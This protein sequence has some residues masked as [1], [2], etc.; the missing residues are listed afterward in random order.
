MTKQ[1]QI[2]LHHMDCMEF[3]RGLPDKAF[4]LAICDPPYGIGASSSMNMGHR[5]KNFKLQAYKK[6]DWDNNIPNA[7]YFNELF[8]VSRNQI[9]WGGNY[10]T[11]YLPVSKC[12][13]VWDKEQPEGISFGMHE[14]AW[15][16]FLSQPKICRVSISSGSN[17]CSSDIE[18]AKKY[19]RIHPT[20]K[21]VA[22]YKWLLKNYAK[23]GDRILDTH[24]GSM[25]IALACFDMGFDLDLCEIDADYFKAGK[26]RFDRHINR[27]HEGM[28]TPIRDETDYSKIGGIFAT[29]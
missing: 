29:V 2:N 27:W 15:T 28:D 11:A 9:I 12:W 10:M 20:Q 18:K 24:G 25:S 16:T 26:E 19:G 5:S 14:L 13:I 22:L 7:E 3:M 1:P 8:R 21:P 17:R 23:P 6:K 4:E